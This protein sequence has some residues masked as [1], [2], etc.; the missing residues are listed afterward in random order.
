MNGRNN[1][2]FERLLNKFKKLNSADG[3]VYLDKNTDLFWK[4]TKQ[5]LDLADDIYII[6]KLQ[7]EKAK[8]QCNGST[9]QIMPDSQQEMDC[10]RIIQLFA[11]ELV[12]F[13]DI[14][15]LTRFLSLFSFSEALPSRIAHLMTRCIHNDN[16][17]DK[18]HCYLNENQYNSLIESLEECR[19]LQKIANK[20]VDEHREN[21]RLREVTS[22]Q[23][24]KFTSGLFAAS[25]KKKK[26]PKDDSRQTARRSPPHF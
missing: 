8:N 2:R 5:S 17:L 20:I 19:R 13:N 12:Q 10:V 24:S 7:I 3:L 1:R 23:Q 16:D 6:F 18:V 21:L 22:A 11:Y 25:D 14:N 9:A 26:D 4:S 15:V